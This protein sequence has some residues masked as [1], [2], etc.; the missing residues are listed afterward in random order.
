MT[1]SVPKN[2]SVEGFEE[3]LVLRLAGEDIGG[4]WYRVVTEMITK[5]D[6]RS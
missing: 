2:H 5:S 1:F 6:L 3:G 4:S